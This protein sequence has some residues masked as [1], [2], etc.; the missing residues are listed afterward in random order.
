MIVTHIFNTLLR[1]IHSFRILNM[2][3]FFS[4]YEHTE[5]NLENSHMLWTITFTH[6]TKKKCQIYPLRRKKFK[7]VRLCLRRAEKWS[8]FLRRPE[9]VSTF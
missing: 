1:R 6:G 2:L 4:P 3:T 5:S 8:T 7:N 9:N